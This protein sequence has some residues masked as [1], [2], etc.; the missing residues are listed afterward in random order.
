MKKVTFLECSEFDE[1]VKNTYGRIYSFQQQ[2][3]C[4]DRGIFKFSL[5]CKEVDLEDFPN[6]E[7]EEVVNGDDMGVSFKAWLECDPK[8]KP[9]SEI[10]KMSIWQFLKWRKS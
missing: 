1:L 6:D 4:K 9:I 5:P 3:G 10:K 2:E 8:E 7:I